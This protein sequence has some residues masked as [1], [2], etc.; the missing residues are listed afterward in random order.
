MKAVV[1]FIVMVD[2]KTNDPNEAVSLARE[3]ANPTSLIV[4]R[5]NYP[6]E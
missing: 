1:H 4:T 3:K 6:E 5:V 2:P